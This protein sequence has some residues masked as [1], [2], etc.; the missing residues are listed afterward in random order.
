MKSL[1]RIL[2]TAVAAVAVSGIASADTI[3]G[4]TATTANTATDLNNILQTIPAW[5]PGAG[6]SSIVSNV[7]GG[8]YTTGVA[9]SSL[10]PA[11]FTYTLVGYNITV[12]ETLTGNYILTNSSTSSSATGTSFI[13]SYTAV[14]LNTT[15]GFIDNT[16]DAVADLYSCS[17]TNIGLPTAG[18]VHQGEQVSST[19][20]GPDPNGPSSGAIALGVAGSGTNSFTSS[21]IN[22]NS[23]FVD[24]GC[25]L[26]GFGFSADNTN[27]A[28]TACLI[29]GNNGA[30]ATGS[31]LLN[32]YF[33]TAT[34]DTTTFQGGNNST[35][36]NTSV[37][38][39][40]TVT[41]DYSAVPIS[42]TPEPTTM[43]L[44]GSALVGLGLLRKR[45]RS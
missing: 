36:Y 22:V 24:L 15:L 41:Y 18:C 11:L 16:H 43:V 30:V 27:N 34:E 7:S 12:N 2:I 10:N 37:T 20:G 8:G 17:T 45:A 33:K 25:E 5:D 29:T 3:I 23:K 4:Y 38:E 26:A 42:T 35:Q 21:P 28:G 40:V 39:Q 32:F 31:A 13:D 44:F 9:M 14:G 6:G 19:G 1:R